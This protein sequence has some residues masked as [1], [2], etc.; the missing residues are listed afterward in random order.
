MKGVSSKMHY[1]RAHK[2]SR[3]VLASLAEH[4]KFEHTPSMTFFNCLSLIILSTL[5]LILYSFRC[6]YVQVYFDYLW[7]E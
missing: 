1:F 2:I 7:K 3:A 4:L 6:H 5:F